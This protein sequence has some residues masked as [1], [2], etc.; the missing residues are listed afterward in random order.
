MTTLEVDIVITFCGGFIVQCVKIMQSTLLSTFVF[1]V[2]V[3][4]RLNII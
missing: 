1:V 3:L 4:A 2:S